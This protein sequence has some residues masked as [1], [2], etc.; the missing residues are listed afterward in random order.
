M[1]K[2]TKKNLIQLKCQN[3]NILRKRKRKCLAKMNGLVALENLS[4]SLTT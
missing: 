1:R 4:T 3:E 2:T